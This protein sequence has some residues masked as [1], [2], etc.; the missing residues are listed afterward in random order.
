M[1]G[2]LKWGM[3]TLQLSP[4]SVN[5][6]IHRQFMANLWQGLRLALLRTPQAHASLDQLLCL[7]AL[8]WACALVVDRAEI[9]GMATLAPWGV[10]AEAAR[11]YFWLATLG[12]I[13]LLP[14][15]RCAFLPL[16]VSLAAADIVIWLAWY[17]MGFV[18]P[19][20][21]AD[22]AE[23]LQTQ[24]WWLFLLWQVAI[25]AVA[26]RAGTR[27]RTL[28]PVS[29]PPSEAGTAP[30]MAPRARRP[31]AQILAVV[32]YALALQANLNLLPDYP[33]WEDSPQAVAALDVETLYYRQPTLT[34]AS[35]AEV[36]PGVPGRRELFVVSFA[37]YGGQDVFKREAEQVARILG[38]RYAAE[39]RTVTLINNPQ[40]L[41][42]H[43]LASRSNLAWV[44]KGLADRMQRDEDILFLFLTSHGAEDGEFVVELGDLGLNPLTPEDVRTLLDEARI[45]WR[46]VVVSACYSGQFASAVASPQTLLITAAAHDR[47]SFGCAHARRW[48]YFGAAYFR[49]ALAGTLSFAEAFEQAR[50]AVSRRER[51]EGKE[52]SSPQMYLGEEI[53]DVL[54]DYERG[55]S[56]GR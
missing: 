30:A 46:V 51:A 40:T 4:N 17:L 33:L 52:P 6:A 32:L 56:P 26:L 29:T 43:P 1:R 13:T 36:T 31:L 28:A 50:E 41:D 15:V 48:T 45:R 37:G 16:A 35:L 14:G 54:A 55:L 21:P 22:A 49:D 10:V 38:Q 18:L 47:T 11:S 42:S 20:L 25:F 7:L 24:L 44:L 3:M 19:R 8:G 39:S 2:T 53:R 9:A 5:P 27:Q 34:A 23:T 12:L